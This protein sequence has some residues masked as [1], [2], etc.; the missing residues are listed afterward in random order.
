[1]KGVKQNFSKIMDMK[2]NYEWKRGSFETDFQGL[3]YVC[4]K[5]IPKLISLVSSTWFGDI[6]MSE[7]SLL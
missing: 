4:M 5:T 2:R 1:M 3:Q 6:T 7:I